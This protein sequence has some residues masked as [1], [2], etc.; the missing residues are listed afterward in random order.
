MLITHFLEKSFYLCSEYYI[1]LYNMNKKL[2]AALSLKCKDMG[3]T[4]KAL[5]ELTTLGSTDL[6]D[7]ASDEDISKKVDFLEPFAKAMQGEI[8][9]K[10]SKKTP[11]KKQSKEEEGNKG[12]EEGDEAPEWFKK[13]RAA[14]DAALKAL[15]DENAELK[16]EKAK[17]Q[18]QSEIAAKA[19]KLGIPN[20]LLKRMTFA[21]DADLDKE[22]AEI[23][24]DL[25]NNNLV[26][27]EQAHE[28]SKADEEAMKASAEAWAKSL[29]DNK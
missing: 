26:P 21:D 14:N 23:K 7:D 4:D 16:A 20:Y 1:P 25:V 12:E 8:T 5:D 22:L 3:L 28:T 17:E 15:Q 2:R 9:R 27:K 18:R 6:A 13:Y 24:Q 29:P 19:K 11:L 10:T